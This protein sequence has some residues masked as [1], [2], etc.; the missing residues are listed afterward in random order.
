MDP[1]FWYLK[2]QGNTVR[3][4]TGEE[5]GASR[6]RSVVAKRPLLLDGIFG[7]LLFI[8]GVTDRFLCSRFLLGCFRE[9]NDACLG[10]RYVI[11]MAG[12][13]ANVAA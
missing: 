4:G 1:F 9:K 8:I 6:F 13:E 5:Q 3:A 7:S 10:V 12:S 2:H 11:A